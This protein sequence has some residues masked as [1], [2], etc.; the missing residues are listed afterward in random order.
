MA[1]CYLLGFS[2]LGATAFGERKMLVVDAYLSEVEEYPAS[3]NACP[4]H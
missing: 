2:L 4:W 3:L 1:T